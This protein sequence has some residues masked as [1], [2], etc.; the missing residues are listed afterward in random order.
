MG[1]KKNLPGGL[2]GNSHLKNHVDLRDCE[3]WT[4]SDPK[5]FSQMVVQNGDEYHGRKYNITLR[6]KDHQS[7]L[8]ILNSKNPVQI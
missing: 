7:G 8:N 2:T 5:I 4:K 1:K 6:N 3:G